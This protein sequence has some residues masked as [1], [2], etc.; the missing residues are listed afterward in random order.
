MYRVSKVNSKWHA[1]IYIFILGDN[2]C[3]VSD[4]TKGYNCLNNELCVN[5]RCECKPGYT[6]LNNECI[7]N[8][9]NP[10]ARIQPDS[11]DIQKSD[12]HSHVAVAVVVPVFLII[13]II[14]SFIV[15]RKYNLVTW[16]SNKINQRN[17][18]YDEPMIGEEDDDPPLS[19]A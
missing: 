5:G 19:G 1:D 6:K 14:G 3:S 18:L 15:I 9:S 12:E 16:V 13:F 4:T 11:P 8:S 10:A 17:T 7:K 2:V